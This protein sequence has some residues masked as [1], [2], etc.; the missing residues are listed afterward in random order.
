MNKDEIMTLIKAMIPPGKTIA[1]REVAIKIAEQRQV[2]A[3]GSQHKL[4]PWQKYLPEIKAIAKQM[5]LNGD[6]VFI[7]K[8]KLIHPDEARGVFRYGLPETV[9]ENTRETKSESKSE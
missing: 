2:S 3:G 9:P 5:A 8:K 1:P 6:L 4:E 7:R